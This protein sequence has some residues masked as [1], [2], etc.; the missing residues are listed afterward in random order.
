MPSAPGVD[1]Y[2]AMEIKES[3]GPLGV[4]V[5]P[6]IHGHYSFIYL[7][8]SLKI[9]SP[10]VVEGQPC[11]NRSFPFRSEIAEFPIFR[12]EALIFML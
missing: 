12:V 3:N 5:A 9:E 1:I 4:S 2:V 6:W 7:A 10:S 8:L 11:L